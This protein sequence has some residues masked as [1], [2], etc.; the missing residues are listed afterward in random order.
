MK[1]HLNHLS[2]LLLTAFSLSILSSAT[3]A[4]WGVG[5]RLGNEEMRYKDNNDIKIGAIFDIQYQGSK[6]N[7]DDK[8]MSYNFTNS[9][10]LA[11]EVMAGSKN[12]GFTAKENKLFK[13]MSNRDNSID[14]GGRIIAETN[15]GAAVLDVT[16][17]LTASKGYEASFKLGGILPHAPHWTGE[18]KINVAAMGG[19]RY[20]SKKV[21]DYYYGVKNNEATSKRSAYRAKSAIT[22]FVGVEAQAN[23][24]PHISLRG[25]LGVEKTAKAIRNSPLTDDKNYNAEARLGLIYWF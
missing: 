17:D 2:T 10:T 1:I 19:L 14:L 13:G 9:N 8:V 12:R 5:L 20:Q 6:F 21:T 4:D 22:P 23:L 15:F 7:I 3:Y 25:S 18:R 16:K 11:A 24:T